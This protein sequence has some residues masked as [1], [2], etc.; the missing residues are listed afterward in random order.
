M[1]PAISKG[2][3]AKLMMK[4][5]SDMPTP[6]FEL[7]GSDLWSNMLPPPKI[8]SKAESVRVV[9]RCRPLNKK[10]ITDGHEAIVQMFPD[11]GRCE[12]RNPKSGE[13]PKVFT[14]D[15]VYGADSKQRDLYDETFRD[16]VQ[17]VLDGFNGTIFAYG[18]TGTGK[19][20]TMQ[21]EKN[22]PELKGVIPHSFDHIFQH[23]AQ[24]ENQQ[25][26]VRAS[27]LEIY[28]EEIRDLLSKDQSK[29]LELK[30]RPDTGVYVKDLSSFVTKSIKEIEHVMNVGNQNR[31]VGATDMNEHSSRSHA[32]FIITIEC[33]EEGGD[34]ENH[35]RVGK[36]NLVD[37][38]GSERQTKTG[39]QG[40]RFKEATK[41]NL[42][43][44]ALGNVISALVDGKSTHIPYRDSKLTRLLQDSLGGNAKT[45]MVANVGPASWNFDETITTLRYA[46]RAKNIKNKPKINEDPK[47]ALLREFQEEISRLKQALSGKG[48]KKKKGHRKRR[49]P[50]GEPL[51]DDE[52]EE[53]GEEDVEGFL[54]EQKA[55]LEQEKNAIINDKNLIAEEKERLLAEAVEKENKL[56]KER[57]A[58]EALAKKIQ[59]MESKLLSGGNIVDHTN[60]QQRAL[61]QRKKEIADQ[62]RRE[63]EIQQKLEEEEEN[64][65][66]IE[67]T[68]TSL[69]QEVEIKT[70]KLKRLFAK[71][72]ATKQEI[73][74]LKD[75]HIRE[76]QEL[77]QTQNEIMRELKLKVL[78]IE[79]FIPPEDKN[80]VVNRAFYDEEEDTWKL[81]PLTKL[82]SSTMA[83]RP[84]SAVGN[85]RPVAEY[86]RMAASMGGSIRY[87][88][89][90]I[91]QVE[92][93]MPNRTTR[94]YE[95]PTVAPKIQAALDAALQDE[96]DIDI[97]GS[98]AVFSSKANKMKP[99]KRQIPRPK[100]RPQE[101]FPTSRGLVPK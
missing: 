59:A 63:R 56:Q 31:S 84:V 73:Q 68:Y 93:D 41:I 64:A 39:S 40:D 101:V 74:D 44:S 26:L 92:L 55:K 65:L 37:L 46:N 54:Q 76:R 48:P 53:E 71:L 1:G 45:V 24:T 82:G 29:R 11:R 38:A 6:R 52:D 32:I 28:M 34:G 94:D 67:E 23:I 50:D 33:S 96:E 60:E 10:E 7:G 47:D 5:P 21:G 15:F 14:F 75:E 78:I 83:K 86:A 22:N 89:E 61:E 57:E 12:V 90:N 35:I 9:V 69:Q 30:E 91:L 79:N 20:Y 70:K 3:E 88:G 2:D 85:K 27:Y 51:S 4:H 36:L 13:Q 77:E 25:Y 95:G 72:Q 97:D 99:K 100:P 18:Q 42:S 8:P 58:K 43:L 16:L 49:G 66:K 98:P 80:K 62:R 87:K 19:T 17:A 81:Q